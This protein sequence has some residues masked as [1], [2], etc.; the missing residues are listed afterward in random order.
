[1]PSTAPVHTRRPARVPGITPAALLLL[2]A[3]LLLFGAAPASAQAQVE[4]WCSARDVG[5]SQ[6]CEIRQHRFAMTAGELSIDVGA[7][8]SIQVE[9]YNGSEV[10]VTARVT[11]RGRTADAARDLAQRVQVRAGAGE[12]RAT[13]P[14]TSGTESWTV[15]VRV[16]VPHGVALESRTTNG[17]ISIAGTRAAVQAR[18]T[19]GAITVADA[20]GR[21]DVRSTNGT[22]R[23]AVAA[24]AA[25]LESVQLRTTNGAVQ[26]TVPE[27]T[28]ARLELSTTNG[29][30]TTDIPV[31]VQGRINR[32]QVS[33]VLGSGGPEIRIATTNGAIRISHP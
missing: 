19:N 17:S 14:R 29:G 26:L 16:Q 27:G 22:I 24:G 11:A 9:G 7:N 28:S 1:M 30:I 32:R 3:A 5:R 12:V 21:L 18:T 33:A 6:H 23:A 25:P 10:R 8:G 2:G 13:G 4:E 31:A 20:V 15:S